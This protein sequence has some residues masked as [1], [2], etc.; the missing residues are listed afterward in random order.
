MIQYHIPNAIAYEYG[1]FG[2]VVR[3][4]GPMAAQNPFQFS[5][6]YTDSETGLDYYGYRY[7]QPSTG[8]WLSR[9]PIEEDGGLNL[10]GFL[11]ND[12]INQ[13]DG[14]GLM[15][16][17]EMEADQKLWDNAVKKETC[18][19]NKT[20]GVVSVSITGAASGATVNMA[21]TIKKVGCVLEIIQYYWWNCFTAQNEYGHGNMLLHPGNHDDPPWQHS[22]WN[23]GGATYSL[24]HAGSYNIIS[25]YFFDSSHWNW[26]AAVLYIYCA[27]DGHKHAALSGYSNEWEF[28]WDGTHNAWT[29]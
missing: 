14:V 17:S 9:D 19:C 24:S 11:A 28:T 29:H 12:G 27:K 26:Q 6:K 10:Y 18:C 25:N 21:A 7:Y 23:P 8:R 13:V 16:E 22:G 2:E 1:P 5:T 15:T 3:A 4:S 20:A